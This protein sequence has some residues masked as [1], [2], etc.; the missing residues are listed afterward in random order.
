MCLAADLSCVET[1]NEDRMNRERSGTRRMAVRTFLSDVAITCGT[2][3]AIL[4]FIDW[5][6]TRRQK[7]WIRDITTQAWYWLSVQTPQTYLRYART[8]VAFVCCLISGLIYVF[9]AQISDPPPFIHESP[10]ARVWITWGIFGAT[11]AIFWYFLGYRIYSWLIDGTKPFKIFRDITGLSIVVYLLIFFPLI[12]DAPGVGLLA[13]SVAWIWFL[14]TDVLFFPIVMI[15]FPTQ[16]FI[17]AISVLMLVFAVL[18]E[19]IVRIVE[20]DKGPVLAVSALLT[21]VGAIVKSIT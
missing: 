16:V 18:R 17:L 11:I 14:V 15:L 19:I 13:T 7:E 4:V 6:L 1:K 21:V 9:S 3:S 8:K 5:L 20:S 2:G 12:L 10:D